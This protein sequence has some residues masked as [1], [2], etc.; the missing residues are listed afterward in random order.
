[1]KNKLKINLEKLTE[2]LFFVK[3]STVSPYPER[4]DVNVSWLLVHCLVYLLIIIL[5][6]NEH[7][8]WKPKLEY[9]Q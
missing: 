4:F 5:K 7:L 9:D 8:R 2:L 3:Q 6:Q 1:M